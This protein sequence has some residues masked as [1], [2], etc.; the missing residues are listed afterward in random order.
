MIVTEEFRETV[1]SIVSDMAQVHCV[2]IFCASS[3]QYESS[4]KKCP[5]VSGIYSDIESIC[6]ELE[7]G[8]QD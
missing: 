5:K 3:F 4:L 6:N 7:N 1:L 8:V 2:Y